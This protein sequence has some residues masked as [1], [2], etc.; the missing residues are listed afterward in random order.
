MSLLTGASLWQ[1]DDTNKK[2]I[3]TMK[4]PEKIASYNDVEENLN[5]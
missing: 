2:R 4:K 5:R 3:S 1:N